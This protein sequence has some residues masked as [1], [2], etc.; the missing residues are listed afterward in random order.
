MYLVEIAPPEIRA[1]LA[2][3]YNTLC[4]QQNEDLQGDTI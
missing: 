1:T 4:K 3:T 2:G